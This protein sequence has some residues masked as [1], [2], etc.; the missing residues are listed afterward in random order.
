V[1]RTLL[2]CALVAGT[3]SLPAS[4]AQAEA[5]Q[6][7]ATY[8]T[9]VTATSANL[10]AEISPGGASTTYRFDYLTL[11]AYRANEEAGKDPFTGASKAP[12]S[13]SA[14]AGAGSVAV[15]VTQHLTNLKPLTLYRFRAVA[16]NAEGTATS[17]PVRSFGTEAPTNV[18]RLLDNRAW[19]QVSPLDKNGG[20]IQA[21]EA[22]FGGGVFQAA[23]N[24]N[25]LTYSSADSFASPQGAPAGSQYIAT[26]SASGWQTENVTAPLEAGGYGDHP[27]GVPYQ[28]FSTDLARAIML[29]PRRCAGGC[30]RSYSVRES[31][32]GSTTTSPELAGLRF[33]GASTDLRLAVLSSPEGLYRWSEAGFELLSAAP[34]AALAASAGAISTDGNRGYLT[35]GGDLY[36]SEGAQTTQV[37][38]AQGGG[39]EFQTAS[40]DG[41]FAFFAKAEHLYRYDAD[42]ESSTDLTP[43]GGVLGVL[44][45]SADGSKAYYQDAAGLFLW[46]GGATEEVAPGPNAAAPSNYPPATGTARVSPDGAHLLFLSQAELSGYENN[47]FLEAFLYGPPPGGGAP[48]LACVSCNPTGE[49]PEGSA[50]IPGA[51]SNGQLP[52]ATRAYKP[53]ALSDDGQRAFFE[54]ADDLA[55]QDSNNEVDVYEWEAQGKGSCAREGGCTGLISNGR[56]AGRSTFIDASTDGSSAFFLTDAS[57]AFGDAASYDLYVAREGGGFP[58]PPN[59]IPCVGDACQALPEAPEDPTPGTLVPNSGNPARRFT[60]AKEPR[61]HKPKKDKKDKKD[62]H[63][64]RKHGGKR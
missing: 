8:V 21:P 55:I 12:L 32:S 51:I 48:T 58:A 6:I 20:E 24:G 10:R 28:L 5:P 13:G 40:E 4:R 2:L 27:D 26:R 50:S 38:E 56:G 31:Q 17:D 42:S 25:S 53:R 57:L 3:L 7:E 54:S 39:G 1:A 43:T 33:E 18:F 61:G 22:I 52:T 60:K 44:G 19:E 11:A 62:K 64:K 34:G 16:T 14:S 63:R 45:A 30:P 41:R 9:D 47:G 49:R 23:S 37:D 59:V 35:Q 29:D 15:T 36:L 46:E